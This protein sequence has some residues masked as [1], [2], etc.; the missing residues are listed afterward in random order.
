VLFID[1]AAS[2]NGLEHAACLIGPVDA[3]SVHETLAARLSA[4]KWNGFHG[5]QHRALERVSAA[6]ATLYRFAV[7][8]AARIAS[9]RLAPVLV[10][11]DGDLAVLGACVEQRA[12]NEQETV[13]RPATP[14]GH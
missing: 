3:R 8:N 5:A 12:G 4:P 7:A 1:D 2:N 6:A 14:A 9:I 11:P 10:C 13:A